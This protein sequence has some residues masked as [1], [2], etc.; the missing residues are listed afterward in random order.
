MHDATRPTFTIVIPTY[1]Y[2]RFVGRAIESALAQSGD[3]YEVLVIDDGSTDDTPARVA[4]YVGRVRFERHANCGAA[5]TRNRGAELARGHYLLFLDADDR[6]RADALAHFREALAARPDLRFVF[7]H[8]LSISIDGT[9]HAARPQPTLRNN[10]DDFR[11]FLDRTFG[12]SHGTVLMRRDNFDV[13]RYPAGISNGED[14]VLFA[15]SLALFPCETIPH[16]L[17]EIHA[18]DARI[19]N[20]IDRIRESGL[21]VVDALF[22]PDVLPDWA[23]AF[24]PLFLARRHLSLARSFLHGKCYR[25]ARAH[26]QAAFRTRWTLALNPTHAARWLRTLGRADAA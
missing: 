21:R 16:A 17:A 10:H 2:G 23:M 19:R 12:I 6:L 18:H 14:L 25:E 11:D 15:Q 4:P 1:N 8:H 7:G 24:R 3:D 22:R 20:N 13:V 9:S 5:A 26:Y